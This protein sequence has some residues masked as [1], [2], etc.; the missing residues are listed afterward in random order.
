MWWNVTACPQPCVCVCV[1]ARVRAY[2]LSRVWLFAT[3]WSITHQAHL[4]MGFS[5]QEYWSGLPFPTPG[6]LPD[7]RIEPV[8]LGSPALADRFFITGNHLGSP[9]SETQSHMILPAELQV[10]FTVLKGTY[11][12]SLYLRNSHII[13]SYL[14]RHSLSY[15]LIGALYIS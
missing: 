3:R 9:L 15:K 4:P 5:R 7:P 1:C 11:C 14:Q 10:P 2:M 6:D 13:H 8:S 12:K